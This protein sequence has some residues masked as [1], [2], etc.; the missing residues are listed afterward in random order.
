MSDSCGIITVRNLTEGLPKKS[1]AQDS[2]EYS[3]APSG[4]PSGICQKVLPSKDILT[5]NG[6][7]NIP[8]AK[9]RVSFIRK[10]DSHGK[11]EVNG[12]TYFIKRRLEGQYVVAT[13]FTH[14]KRLVVKQENKIIRSFSF[15]IKDRVVTPTLPVAKRRT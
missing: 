1:M 11:N 6:N 13:I 3:E 15:P 4:S 7:L 12:S 2:L 8:I 9:E 5:S 14:I 10:V